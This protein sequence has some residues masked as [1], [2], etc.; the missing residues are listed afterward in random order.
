MQTSKT[1]VR[2]ASRKHLKPRIGSPSEDGMGAEGSNPG[3]LQRSLSIV[4]SRGMH[5][6]GPANF[7]TTHTMHLA[8]SSNASLRS[9][10]LT[11]IETF[12]STPSFWKKYRCTKTSQGVTRGC[13]SPSRPCNLIDPH[14]HL[15]KKDLPFAPR[16]AHRVAKL[17]GGIADPSARTDGQNCL[18]DSDEARAQPVLETKERGGRGGPHWGSRPSDKLEY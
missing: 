12:L 14:F 18:E 3:G 7:S 11:L 9:T 17:G 6:Q 8:L 10:P 5:L 16:R 2:R 4:W 15:C 1:A 13:P